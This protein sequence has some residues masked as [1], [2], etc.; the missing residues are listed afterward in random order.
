MNNNPD[1]KTN[2]NGTFNLNSDVINAAKKGDKKALLNSLSSDELEKLN[3]VLNDK[4]KLES[5][6][7]TPQAMAIFKALGGKNG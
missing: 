7:K 1:S 2:T 4:Q 3:S 6:L 5:I